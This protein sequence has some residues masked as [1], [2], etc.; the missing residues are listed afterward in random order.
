VAKGGVVVLD[1]R[2][3]RLGARKGGKRGKGEGKGDSSHAFLPATLPAGLVCVTARVGRLAGHG[4]D[5]DTEL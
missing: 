2:R 5:D 1:R 3:R 4:A